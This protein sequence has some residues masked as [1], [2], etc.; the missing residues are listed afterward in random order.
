VKAAVSA[1]FRFR[2]GAFVPRRRV[3]PERSAHQGP[4]GEVPVLGEAVLQGWALLLEKAWEWTSV[5]RLRW[6]SMSV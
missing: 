3:P 5:L 4:T 2:S 6:V 1:A